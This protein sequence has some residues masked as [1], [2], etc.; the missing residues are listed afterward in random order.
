MWLEPPAMEVALWQPAG[1]SKPLVHR[2]AAGEPAQVLPLG[3]AAPVCPHWQEPLMQRFAA[4]GAQV[5]QLTP[6]VP[7]VEVPWVV[8]H[9]VAVQQP[10]HSAGSHAHVPAVHRSPT[11]QG[12]PVPQPQV[13]LVRQ[14]SEWVS[15]VPQVLPLGPHA[16]VLLLVTQVLPWQQPL[17]HEVALQTHA[18]PWQR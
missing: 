9:D 7:Q 14:L 6:P 18:P 15:H 10:V 12:A 1:S 3:Q 4:G 16:V 8:L 2:H 13:P 5:A 11:P 17:G